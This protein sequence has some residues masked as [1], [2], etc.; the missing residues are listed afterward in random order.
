MNRSFPSEGWAAWGRESLQPRARAGVGEGAGAKPSLGGREGKPH[1]RRYRSG[2][3]RWAKPSERP[4]AV[5]TQRPAAP[6]PTSK[7]LPSWPEEG[8]SPPFLTVSPPASLGL[9]PGL[10]RGTAPPPQSLRSLSHWPDWEPSSTTSPALWAQLS[11][12]SSHMC[13]QARFLLGEKQAGPNRTTLETD[14][15]RRNTDRPTA[16]LLRPPPPGWCAHRQ[17]QAEVGTGG[18]LGRTLWRLSPS[19]FSLHPPGNLRGLSSE[20]PALQTWEGR[21]GGG[22]AL[23]R[24]SCPQL[25]RLGVWV[26]TA[27]GRSVRPPGSSPFDT[28][29]TTSSQQGGQPSAQRVPPTFTPPPA[30]RKQEGGPSSSP[31][32]PGASVGPP[33]SPPPP[34]PRRPG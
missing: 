34:G 13:P 9:S 31:S 17:A 26:C 6:S 22:E 2:G 28:H 7:G 14:L 11:G 21:L 25:S 3:G 10:R 8:D 20:V 1:M 15:S 23:R 33:A 16:R 29:G 5:L 4:D 18:P 19:L 24:P 30:A 12:S 32:S 27:P